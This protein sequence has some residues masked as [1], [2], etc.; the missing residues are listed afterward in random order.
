M[1]NLKESLVP[2]LNPDEA[3][4]SAVA[5]TGKRGR[6]APPPTERIPVLRWIKEHLA[7]SY[8]NVFVTLV[9]LAA[10][11]Y[12][13]PALVEWGLIN[14]V[15]TAESHEECRAASGAC[16]AVIQEKHRPM[17]F[18]VY[19]YE[20]HW[21]L[22]LA[23]II[24]ISAVGITMLRRFWSY[25]VLVPL[26]L[27]TLASTLSL[28]WG[29]V[30][31]L[32]AVD[33]TQWGGLPLTMVLFSGTLVVGFPLS[34]ILALGRR[35]HMPMVKAVSVVFIECLR[36]VPLITILFFAVNVFPLFLPQG[37]EFDKMLRVMVGMAIFFACYEAEVIRG[38][39]QAIPRG[40][41][42]AAEA[43]GLGYWQTMTYIILPQA[44][45]ICLPGIVNHVIAAFK[46]TSFV[47]I[48]GLFDMLTATTSVLQDPVWRRFTVEAY[49]C[50]GFVYFIF[51]FALSKYSQLVER[52]LSEDKRF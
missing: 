4:A 19:P 24:Y 25:V 33:T 6:T 49:L 11:Y 3:S 34:I 39:L 50:V 10:L 16:W 18:G 7:S 15:F 17:F 48:I 2:R 30:F 28:L 9:C 21:R 8:F 31:G 40:Q 13:V 51:C 47:L 14:A 32:P 36:G 42:E 45:R 27:F 1:T 37:L 20:E 43:L 29:G 41:Y 46:N 44:L 52:W 12:S 35:S 26:W 23:L 5:Q 22:V 38:G